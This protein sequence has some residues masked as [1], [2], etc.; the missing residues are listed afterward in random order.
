[1]LAA[2]P[3]APACIADA[4]M[5][6]M[7][8]VLLDA[9]LAYAA[10][11]WPV[12]PC[13]PK[14]KQP[15]IK[16]GFKNASRDPQQ[17]SEWLKKWPKALIAVATGPESGI[18]VV[19]F[20]A[21]E[22]KDT[23]EV[24]E[25]P[26]LI[27]A[28]EEHVR[29]KMPKTCTSNTPRGGRHFFF[30]LPD[31]GQI[32]SR[33]GIIPR[34]D[35]KGAGGYVIVP[36]SVRADGVPYTWAAAPEECPPAPPPIGLVSALEGKASLSLARP[37]PSGDT[38]KDRY[39]AAYVSSALTGEAS[40]VAATSSGG[41]NARLNQAAFR[42]G[43]IIEFC[44]LTERQV[45]DTLEDAAA[46]CGLTTDDGAASVRKTIA[47]GLRAGR[48]KPRP[49]SV[50]PRE[51]HPPTTPNGGALRSSSAAEQSGKP[52]RARRELLVAAAGAASEA[53][54]RSYDL[55]L[56]DGVQRELDTVLWQNELTDL[57]NAERFKQRFADCLIWV[58]GRGWLHYDRGSWTE[59][60]A[61]A[62]ALRG[63]QIVARSI[64]QEADYLRTSEHDEVVDVKARG[65]K[66][67][68]EVRR[69]DLVSDWG[70]QSEDSRRLIAMVKQ[71]EPLCMVSPAQLDRDPYKI[72]VRNGTLVLSRST[73]GE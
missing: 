44:E 67:E 46:R 70:R 31:D 13:H 48:S 64:Q 62:L 32:P 34:V 33:I 41:R 15:L 47:S 10:R 72:N 18:F 6:A 19:D 53:T 11:G 57:G 42:I 52:D 7:S 61:N 69:S 29:C 30:A 40:A 21:G 54:G 56:D 23:G 12:L 60:G 24:F 58:T 49:P 26:E 59:D 9:A 66:H 43:Q 51:R 63:A 71:A 37:E 14:T 38:Y 3:E 55:P 36:P 2:V 5:S 65:T 4:R 20:D 22:D 17:I 16:G 35:V 68:K 28:F 50:A 8:S 73:E 27:A 45:I 25:L 1:M 39:S